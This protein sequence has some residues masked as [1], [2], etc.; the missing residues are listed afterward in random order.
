MISK[1]AVIP[2][3][4]TCQSGSERDGCSQPPGSCDIPCGQSCNLLLLPVELAAPELVGSG[5]QGASGF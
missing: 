1:D 4:R 5:D 2:G 3:Q